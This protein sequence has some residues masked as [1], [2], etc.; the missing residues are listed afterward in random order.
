MFKNCLICDASFDAIRH[1]SKCCSEACKR[2]YTN[3]K[4]KALYATRRYIKLCKICTN[5]FEATYHEQ[6]CSECKSIKREHVFEIIEKEMRCKYCNVIVEIVYKKNNRRNVP[7]E[8][9][10]VCDTC[11]DKN[12]QMIS[13]RMKIDNPVFKMSQEQINDMRLKWKQRY[14]NLD[15]KIKQERLQKLH[16][17]LSRWKSNQNFSEWQQMFKQMASERMRQFNPMFLKEVRDKVKT[18]NIARGNFLKRKRGPTHHLWKG[19][20]PRAGLIRTRL[21]VAWTRP[22]LM[23]DG[24]RCVLCGSNKKLEV[25]HLSETFKDILQKFLNGALIKDISEEEF[26]SLSDSVVEYH[27]MVE[28]IT[29][30]I[31][32]HRTI[33]PQRR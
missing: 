21:Y 16:D 28:G 31:D 20:S 9:N 26:N 11:R 8:Y 23:R 1:D 22:I 24:F 14:K 25:H 12:K 30:C 15:P 33:D 3:K 19:T 5:E 29:V 27:K 7:T 32:C 2:K 17:G 13:E 4:S 10:S 6:V 18:T